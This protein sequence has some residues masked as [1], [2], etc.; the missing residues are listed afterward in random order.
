MTHLGFNIFQDGVLEHSYFFVGSLM[1][2]T[3]FNA[4]IPEESRTYLHT[5]ITMTS[6]HRISFN[7]TLVI[8][9]ASSINIFM[10][11]PQFAS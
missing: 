9:I 1:G 6:G 10:N 4:N 5:T 11:N 2:I 7:S 8:N 3:Y